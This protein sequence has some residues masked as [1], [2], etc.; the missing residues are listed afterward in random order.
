MLTGKILTRKDKTSKNLSTSLQKFLERSSQPVIHKAV[1]QAMRI[2]GQQF[3]M[4]RTIKEAIKRAQKNEAKGYR[5]SYDMLGEAARTAKD[6]ERYFKSYTNAIETISKAAT[7]SKKL[8]DAPG[9]SVKLSALHPRYEFTQRERSLPELIARVRQL[10]LQAMAANIS[11]T[12]DAEEADRLDISMDVIE[13]IFTDP[14][15]AGW[16]GFGLAVQ[17]YQKRAYP[18]IDWLIAL[19][20]QQKRRLMV[21]LVKGAYWDY[22]IKDSQMKGLEGYPVFTRKAATDVSY[23]ACAKKMIAAS[24]AIYS[25]FA[26]HNAQTVAVILDLMGKNREFEFQCL[27]GMGNALYDQ[28]VGK[29]NLQ[30]R[31]YAPVGSHEDLLAYLVRRLLENGA[32]TSFVNRIIDE[33]IPIRDLVVDPIMKMKKYDR[34]PHS[35]IPLPREIFGS[36]RKN[37]QGW[38]YQILKYSKSLT[39]PWL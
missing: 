7:T 3:V 34:K 38:I 4:G 1:Q 25:Q 24:D 39:K 35:Q 31:I 18:F 28:L 14:A 15:F 33:Q 27:H 19:A 16:E 20:R 21:R 37:S 6:A 11:F 32:N 8:F 26:T 36:E 29:D 10:A 2:L 17:A 5:Y 22:E 23:I 9:I 12:V 30:C 13:A